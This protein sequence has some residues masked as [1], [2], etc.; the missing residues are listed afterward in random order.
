MKNREYSN[1]YEILSPKCCSANSRETHSSLKNTLL[2]HAVLK[3]QLFFSSK[4]FYYE[5]KA[6][7]KDGSQLIRNNL[8]NLN[9]NMCRGVIYLQG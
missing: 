7:K 2:R 5:E 3:I 1:L 6:A 8:L 4:K 9:E